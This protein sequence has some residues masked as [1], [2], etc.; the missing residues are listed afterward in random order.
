[1]ELKGFTCLLTVDLY[2]FKL[3]MELLD[4]EVI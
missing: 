4:T 1:M 3:T 2:G